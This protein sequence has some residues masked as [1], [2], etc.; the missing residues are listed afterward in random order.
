[1]KRDMDLIRD[2][3]LA[4]E[5]GQGVFDIRSDETSHALGLGSDEL[6]GMN[7]EEADRWEHNLGLIEQRGLVRFQRSGGGAW[8]VDEVTWEGH[9]FIDSIRDPEIWAQTKVGA[10]KA[11]GFTFDIIIAVVK[12]LIKTK[13]EKHTGVQIDL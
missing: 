7:Q 5:D 3:L 13:L 4:I 1:M 11:G 8:C 12:G 6:T 2:I 9:D 10:R